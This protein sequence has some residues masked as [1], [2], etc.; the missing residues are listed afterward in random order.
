MAISKLLT[1]KYVTPMTKVLF[2]KFK[3]GDVIALF[4]NDTNNR[5]RT[6]MSYMHIGQHGEVDYDS[7]I[8][9]TKSA[10][11]EEYKS[12]LNE[13]INQVSYKDIQ[14]VK[15]YRPKLD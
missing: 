8:N 6:I 3:E 10:T 7:L 5:N 11:E 1:P 15:K 9:V 12:L 4:P 2:R 14:V 13:L